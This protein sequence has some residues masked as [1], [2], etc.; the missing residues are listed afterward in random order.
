M[1]C[2]DKV[3]VT[4]FIDFV[5]LL[6]FCESIKYTPSIGLIP[7]ISLHKMGFIYYNFLV[8]FMIFLSSKCVS[9]F[10]AA[11]V[12]DYCNLNVLSLVI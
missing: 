11:K 6:E 2:S 5:F 9:Y 8:N 3:S 10:L 12:L 1:M 4:G 7:L